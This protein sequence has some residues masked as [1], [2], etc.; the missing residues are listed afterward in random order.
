M[1]H[2]DLFRRRPV[3]SEIN[4][5]TQVS[6]LSYFRFLFDRR[7]VASGAVN[8]KAKRERD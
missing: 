7:G 2:I 5:P 3:P 6:G 1:D 4:F 8:A